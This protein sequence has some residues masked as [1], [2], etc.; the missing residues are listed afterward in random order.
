MKR[1]IASGVIHGVKDNLVRPIVRCIITESGAVVVKLK[2][3]KDEIHAFNLDGVSLKPDD[4]KGLSI[5]Q[6]YELRN[7]RAA[8]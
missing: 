8:S 6:A 5:T 1:G 7:K 2:N 4:L 3:V